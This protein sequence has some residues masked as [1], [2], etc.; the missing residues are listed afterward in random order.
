[1]LAWR[2]GT[3]FDLLAYSYLAAV[4]VPLAIV[5][6]AEQRLP[7]KVVLP[8][9]LVLGGV[10]ATETALNSSYA[11]LLRALAGMV[12]LAAA[13]LVLALAL[14]GLGAGDVK[15]A[16]L[17]GLALAWLSWGAV[18]TGTFV[19]WL[20]AAVA[21][22]VLRLVWRVERHAPMPLGP[23]LALGALV[24]VAVGPPG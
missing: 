16:G 6:L 4:A 2:L 10:F 12:V 21:R 22:V 9:Y 17:L 20:L 5:D 23:Y 14:G 24:T 13:Y 7:S 8:S 19:G 1:M 18:L 15:L 11:D 3:G